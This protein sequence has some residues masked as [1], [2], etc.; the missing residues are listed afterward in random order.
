MSVLLKHENAASEEW[1]K[2]SDPSQRLAE[3]SKVSIRGKAFAESDS[4]VGTVHSKH[5]LEATKGEL[6]KLRASILFT[7]EKLMVIN[8]PTGMAIVHFSKS[9]V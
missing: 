6:S 3:G 9:S 2:A 1:R 4:Q 8:K 5:K 7:D